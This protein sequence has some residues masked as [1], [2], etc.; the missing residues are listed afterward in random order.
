MM[1]HIFRILLQREDYTGRSDVI[2][3]IR[4]YL[5]PARNRMRA[6]HARV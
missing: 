2:Q 5:I 1:L 6:I 4:F 3:N